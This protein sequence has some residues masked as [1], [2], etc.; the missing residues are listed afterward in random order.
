MADDNNP[1][2]L[3]GHPKA[4]LPPGS[5]F[6]DFEDGKGRHE[7]ELVRKQPWL[8]QPCV[9]SLLPNFKPDGNHNGARAG[10]VIYGPYGA[11]MTHSGRV[12]KDPVMRGRHTLYERFMTPPKGSTAQE[13]AKRGR[14]VVNLEIGA[15]DADT[16][17][18][19]AEAP[20][21]ARTVTMRLTA[22]D[23]TE[24]V[25]LKKVASG[26]AVASGTD[27][28]AS[29]LDLAST[30]N[31]NVSGTLHATEANYTLSAG[32][33]LAL[34]FSAGI[35]TARGTITVELEY[36]A[37]GRINP[38]W[39]LSGTNAADSDSLLSATGGIRLT[40]GGSANDQMIISPDA[41][42]G[43]SS[44]G[45]T[46]WNT[47]LKLAMEATIKTGSA[48]TDQVF[49][50]GLKLTNPAPWAVG[51][52]A[53]QIVV[54]YDS[55]TGANLRAVYSIAGTDVDADLSYVDNTETTKKLAVAADTLYHIEIYLDA[56]RKAY[57]FVNG[58]L[59]LTTTA[60][61][62]LTTLDPSIGIQ[63][64]AA[65]TKQLFIRQLACSQDLS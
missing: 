17:H 3:A 20:C 54:Y 15:L 45:I 60:V 63:T 30:V 22:T 34:D 50:V 28:L 14:F 55:S 59:Y 19:I 40:T 43:Q 42:T 12:W 36:T 38:D 47:A 24:T 31:T 23:A 58:R 1:I 6:N 46:T 41:S 57:I 18:Y 53:D 64:L 51:T 52:D 2:L 62:S 27:M 13:S 49:W 16:A 33:A 25:M 7:N 48:I 39:V 35:D 11:M 44:W 26:T 4:G 8:W 61:T 9:A 29:A 56:D 5:L 21:I 37:G 10:D 32:D 65:A